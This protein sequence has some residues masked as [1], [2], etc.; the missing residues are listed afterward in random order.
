MLYENRIKEL[1]K[2]EYES[3]L[4][5]PP[6]STVTLAEN[7]SGTSLSL[8][9][10]SE[11]S[12]TS[13]LSSKDSESKSNYVLATTG[14]YNSSSDITNTESYE[15]LDIINA[16]SIDS[17]DTL[18]KESE[19][20]PKNINMMI[21]A[22]NFE[23]ARK[24][25]AKV[26]S[27]EMGI[28]FHPIVKARNLN[29][30]KDSNLTEAQRNKL[31]VM[32]SE[33]DMVLSSPS[34]IDVQSAPT[35]VQINR[36]RMMTSNECFNIQ[37]NLSTDEVN[38]N[39]PKCDNDNFLV[40][41]NFENVTTDSNK[42]LDVKKWATKKQGRL[43]LDLTKV[44]Q[45]EN[46][47]SPKP[48]NPKFEFEKI[49]PMSVDSA[50]LSTATTPS[51]QLVISFEKT[52]YEA[53]SASD[54][55]T[56]LTTGTALSEGGFCFEIDKAESVSYFEK[57]KSVYNIQNH[58]ENRIL[59]KG[60]SAKDAKT[61]SN[62]CLEV[63]LQQSVLVPLITQMKLVTNELLRFFINDLHY[64]QHLNSLRN[65]F[66]LLDGEFARNITESLFEK[67]YDVNFPLELIN[68]RTLKVLVYKALDYST[69]SQDSSMCLSF[70]INKLP[71][72]FELGDPDVLECISL[73]YKTTWPLNILLPSD[74]ITKYD[75]VFKFL[76]KLHRVSWV[77]QNIFQVDYALKS[78]LC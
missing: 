14:V 10:N 52:D 39:T 48:R 67:L 2:V 22:E 35:I 54:T 55:A 69:K 18:L 51:N 25:K 66:F 24:N 30:T 19:D 42:N 33:F 29:N 7:Q 78:S 62:N 32:S 31:R 72:I 15:S 17:T 60:I 27:L 70:R 37:T 53:H 68:S 23:M 41:K 49:S 13:S 56:E 36:S 46:D 11:F 38:Q 34:P 63:Y 59:D 26:L 47:S 28:T 57:R 61:I 65:Y 20:K 50:P 16:N 5:S 77:L 58:I 44:E 40:G 12:E 75:E 4:G 1:K 71:K 8:G 45:K 6:I 76:L 73:T 9:N 74:T 43:S 3:T 64:L 21:S